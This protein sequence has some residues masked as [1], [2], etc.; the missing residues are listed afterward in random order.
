VLAEQGVDPRLA[1]RVARQ[2][3]DTTF[4]LTGAG[5]VHAAHPLQRC[6]RDLHTVGQHVYFSPSALKRYANTQ[7]GI[8]QPTH[9]L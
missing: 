3:V 2:A 7:F 9:L 8:S 5:A 1:M 4:G 6:F